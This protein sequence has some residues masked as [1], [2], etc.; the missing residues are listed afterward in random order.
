M[1]IE[2]AAT[3]GRT[4]QPADRPRH[5]SEF[6]RSQKRRSKKLQGWV[7]TT[8]N[9]RLPFRFL[10]LSGVNDHRVGNLERLLRTG[11][12]GGIAAARGSGLRPDAHFLGLAHQFG[13]DKRK[14]SQ[15]QEDDD[16]SGHRQ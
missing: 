6:R 11:H 9:L 2:G 16:H 4:Q 7:R 15:H 10:R 8:D 14:A 5:V 12:A 1:T 13:K 3:P